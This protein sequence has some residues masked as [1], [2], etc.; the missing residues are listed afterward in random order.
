MRHRDVTDRDGCRYRQYED[1]RI[2]ILSAPGSADVDVTLHA[3]L[4]WQTITDEI[5]RF[6]LP[7]TVS[8]SHGDPGRWMDQVIQ[9][10]AANEGRY[11]T[12]DRN[13]HGAGLSFGIFQWSQ[14][15]GDL[16]ALLSEMEQQCPRVCR[17]VFGPRWSALVAGTQEA[18][19]RE[20]DGANLWD[21]PWLRCFR[22]AG[23]TPELQHVQMHL[24][25]TGRHFRAAVE[26]ASILG[27][28]T[29]KALALFLD[30]CVQQNPR[31]ARRSA[32][33]TLRRLPVFSYDD[34]S[35][36]L[37]LYA[38][39]CAER[40]RS[41]SEP[42]KPYPASHIEWRE[43]DGEWH[44]W[45]GRFDLYDRVFS[46]RLAILRDPSLEDDTVELPSF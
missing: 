20:V 43:T 13:S 17:S 16:G 1:G 7:S 32:Q 45:A 31:S 23:N 30:T 6:P 24:A 9:R 37:R 29:Q 34:P 21:D 15:S 14:K 12:I 28:A 4:I 25:R 33:T 36:V 41:V 8:S 39:I 42:K 40:Y 22:V 27:V 10:V 3:G 11:T 35:S 18:G 44:A 46:R 26:I 2:Q 5:G 19:V 38:E